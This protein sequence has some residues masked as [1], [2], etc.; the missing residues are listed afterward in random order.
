MEEIGE[1]ITIRG[2][3]VLRSVYLDDATYERIESPSLRPSDIYRLEVFSLYTIYTLVWVNAPVCNALS[4]K[5]T[6][7]RFPLHFYLRGRDSKKRKN[8]PSEQRLLRRVVVGRRRSSSVWSCKIGRE[9][10]VAHSKHSAGSG[11]KYETRLAKRTEAGQV[12]GPD[13]LGDQGPA[14]GLDVLLSV[15]ILPFGGGKTS[16]A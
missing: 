1:I 5:G 16:F 8:G 4:G 13:S 11:G 7:A 9:G 14:V 10:G 3:S 12:A 2:T 15:P 6:P